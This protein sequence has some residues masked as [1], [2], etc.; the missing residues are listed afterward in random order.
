MPI[1]GVVVWEV[2][3]LEVRLVVPGLEVALEVP[4]QEDPQARSQGAVQITEVP[5][6]EEVVGVAEVVDHVFPALQRHPLTPHHYCSS[7]LQ[8]RIHH[9]LEM[10]VVNLVTIFLLRYVESLLLFFSVV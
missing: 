3:N 8:Q 2:L 5:S 7:R 6:L 1:T 10:L 9:H 4:N